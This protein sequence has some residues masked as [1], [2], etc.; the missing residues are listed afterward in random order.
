[1]HYGKAATVATIALALAAGACNRE[2]SES[3]EPAVRDEPT[4]NTDRTAELQRERDDEISR[5]DSRVTEIEREYA[6]ANQ[7]VVS[8][9]RTATAGLRE[10]LKEDVTNVKQAVTDLRTT[11]TEN[12]W[13]RHEEAM[14]R[15]AED[16]EQDV[17]RLAGNLPAVRPQETAGTTGE[18]VSTAPFTSRRDRLVTE[19]RARVDAMEQ[20]LDGVKARA[21]QETEVEDVRARA[22]KLGEDLDRLRSAAADDWWD[23]TK[24]RVT[25]YVDRVERS[26]GRLDD[27][28]G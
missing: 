4:R 25:D 13:N 10:E 20:A 19:L 8:G 14:K 6:E 16:I 22:K 2:A 1:M 15:T 7:K 11:T 18:N 21:A 27:N 26:V 28:K 3:R 24:A 23:V 17:R 5:L 12:W 9:T